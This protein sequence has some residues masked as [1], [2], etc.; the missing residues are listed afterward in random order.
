MRYE[1]EIGANHERG[2]GV[3]RCMEECMSG[4]VDR[5]LLEKECY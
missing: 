1:M 4:W 5:Y 2:G 3:N